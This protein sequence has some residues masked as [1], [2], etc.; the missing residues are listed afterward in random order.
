MLKIGDKAPI[1]SIADQNGNSI[2]TADWLGK[3]IIVYFYPRDLTPTCTEESCNLRDNYSDL[4]QLGFEVYGVSTD[5]EKSH[6][7]FIEKHQ[8]PFVLLADTNKE[9]SMAYGVWG[10][11]KFMGKEFDG[12]HRTTFLIDEKGSISHIFDKVK[13]K[14]H[15]AQIIA[16]LNK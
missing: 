12:I 7:K 2:N 10:P 1:L 6:R 15:S 11:K 5:D 9:M 16:E 14:D 3:K 4:K 8:L 13:S